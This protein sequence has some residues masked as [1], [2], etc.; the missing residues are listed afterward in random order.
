MPLLPAKI[1]AARAGLNMS[2]QALADESG[3]H[4]NTVRGIEL[5]RQVTYE[6]LL[7]CQVALELHGV[8][9]IEY[10]GR[11]GLV[12]P[13]SLSAP[14]AAALR[15]ARGAMML[16]RPEL[17]ELAGLTAGTVSRIE[18]GLG[19]VRSTYLESYIRALGN[20]GIDVVTLDD[21]VLVLLPPLA[22]LKAYL[23]TRR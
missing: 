18:E 6:S 13:N 16:G 22:P 8:E 17:A 4:K 3:L 2:Q 14:G 15:G 9:F 7:Q 12:M 21:G 23:D 1:R 19:S 11:H 10:G 20:I 5:N